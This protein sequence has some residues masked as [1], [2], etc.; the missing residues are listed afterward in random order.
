[1]PTVEG[2]GEIS[3]IA[4]AGIIVEFGSPLCIPTILRTSRYFTVTANGIARHVPSA[5]PS[6]RYQSRANFSWALVTSLVIEIL[7]ELRIPALLL[8]SLSSA[9]AP[10]ARRTE[11]E[12]VNPA[13]LHQHLASQVM[14]VFLPLSR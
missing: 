6:P 11:L 13:A 14:F 1:M 9:I 7:T 8:V 12:I 3:T 5:E 10:L 2:V 4:P